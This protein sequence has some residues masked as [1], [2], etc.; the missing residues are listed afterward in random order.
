MNSTYSLYPV[1]R[2]DKPNK[3][4]LCP[5]YLRYTYKKSWKNVPINKTIDP[6]HWNNEER[7]PRKNCPNRSE[8]IDLIRRKKVE[9]ETLILNYSRE[10]N[11]YPT[12]D[13]LMSIVLTS[14][15]K[16]K[17]WDY[18]FDLFVENQKKNKHVEG[19][20]SEVYRQLKLKLTEFLLEKNL[21]W[22]W[23]GINVSFYNQFVYYLRNNDELKDST[24]GKHI[25]TLKSF[26]NFVSVEYNLINPNQFRG[27]TTLRDEIDFVILN[28]KDIELMKSSVYLSSLITDKDFDLTDNE[29][30]NIRIII[31]LCLTG[32]NFC[33]IQDIKVS[34]F[35]LDDGTENKQIDEND[36]K[37][38]NLYIK[39]TR[40]KL[41][42]VDKK[43]IP[44]IPIT[45]EL[46]D[47]LLLSFSGYE[48]IYKS[49]KYISRISSFF[50]EETIPITRLW[51]LIFS[52]REM[53][54]E[55]RLELLPSYPYLIPK[56][57][58][59]VFNRE[60]KLVLDKIGLNYHIKLVQGTNQ[61]QIEELI[62][63]KCEGVCSR[64]GR[65]SYITNSL[66]KGIHP[67]IVMRTTGIKKTETLRRYENISEKII[68]EQL[69]EKNPKP[70]K[71]QNQEVEKPLDFDLD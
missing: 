7:E 11:D 3:S 43:L 48:E 32:M 10:N 68:V 34:D 14:V 16:V 2:T 61:N 44:I 59:V 51:N 65:R 13:E 39:K 62:I 6:D 60:I 22:S 70:Q 42:I 27:F 23:K 57:H 15:S 24:I 12:S 9:I 28:E 17:T 64:T 20:T 19:S 33:D 1:V 37:P 47:V 26:L 67:S 55:E 5:M 31:L 69:K 40:K 8:I 54:K 66:S 41:K 52:L 38:I 58:N 56:V 29:K 25:K 4:G 63:P 18:Y 46:S 21:K 30:L 45:H 71:I 49:G 53:N 35:F 50:R 36:L